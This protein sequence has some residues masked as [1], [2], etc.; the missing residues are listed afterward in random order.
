VK[1]NWNIDAGR[2][3]HTEQLASEMAALPGVERV[4]YARRAMLSG[5]GGGAV[6]SV[7]LPGPSKHDLFFNQVSPGYFA[8]T[9]ARVLRGRAFNA[10]DTGNATLVVLVN[11]EFARR[12][13]AGRE[14]VG[15][16]I[17]AGGRERQIA[18]IVENGPSNWL[19]E[20][21]APFVYYPYAQRPSGEVT[22]FIETARDPAAMT[23]S[24]RALVRKSGG[25][26]TVREILPYALH[27]RAARR[28]E[29]LAATIGGGLAVLG[30]VLAA[31][32][33]FGVT[34]YAVSRRTREFGVRIA[35]GATGRTLR[36][37]VLEEAA[38]QLAVAAPL[39]WALAW[40]SRKYI[41]KY[42]YGVSATD[43]WILAAAS[44]VVAGVAFAAALLPAQRAA[45][46][47]PSITLR[48]E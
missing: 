39:G 13:F 3:A 1:G 4:A 27:M 21:P 2:I 5:S 17:R 32:G 30:L 36:R 25:A 26:L 6:T 41:V 18:G 10:S 12:F 48:Y 28:T 37:Q 43:P 22:F 11:A 47:D 46:V 16:W 33:L 31:A 7:E 44:A 35:L 42:L 15:Q 19:K 38:L 34:A 8:T 29:E 20:A 40:A 9:G 23:A 45:S 14:A 24:V